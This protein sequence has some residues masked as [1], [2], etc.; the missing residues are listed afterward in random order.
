MLN[1]E[2]R[3]RLLQVARESVLAACCGEA[4]PDLQTDDP[5]LT[6]VQGAFVTLHTS[7]GDLR[8]CIGHIEGVLPLIETIQE[9]AVAAATQ[10]PRFPTVRCEEVPSLQIEISVMSP[11]TEI[12][13][14][15]EIEVGRHGLIVSCGY[16]RGL[17]LPQVATEYNWDCDEFLCHT[18]QKAGLPPH[19]WKDDATKIE[20]FEAEV[21]G[22]PKP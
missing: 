15:E 13:S 9:M 7:D 4:E 8:G 2:Q 14:M 12:Q 17:L 5:M 21:F 11:I 10:D 20:C 16:R 19:A 18:C 1:E 6:A 3:R 22:E